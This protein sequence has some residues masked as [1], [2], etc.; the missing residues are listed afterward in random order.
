MSLFPCRCRCCRRHRE[1]SMVERRRYETLLNVA[2]VETSRMEA[3]VKRSMEAL[4][5]CKGHAETVMREDVY[6]GAHVAAGQL[7]A[8]I[9]KA[10]KA[11]NSSRK[12]IRLDTLDAE[13]LAALATIAEDDLALLDSALSSIDKKKVG[14]DG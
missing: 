11:L 3:D 12:P 9:Q 13:Q 14:E 5:Q 4:L 10:D 6:R 7:L 8:I 2:L 1:E